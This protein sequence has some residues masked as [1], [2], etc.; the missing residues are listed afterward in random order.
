MRSPDL[1]AIPGLSDKFSREFSLELFR[2]GSYTRQFEY[3]VKNAFDHKL[4]QIPI[5][6][7]IG[8]EF[9]A[10]AYAMML[11]DFQIFAQHR[12]HGIYLSFGASPERLRDELL[13]LPTGCS[14]GMSGSNAIQGPEINM[15]GHSGLMGEQ[16]PIS[17]GAAMASGRPTLTV[18]GD[19]SVE[20]DYIYPSLGYAVSKKLPML[21]IC[22]D[23]GLSILTKVEVRRN[24]SAVDMAG[25]LGMPAVEIS[26]DPW[27][28]AHHIEE[29]KNNLP[30]FINIQTVRNLW[31]SGTGTDGPPEW[32]RY[33]L[34]KSEMVRLGLQAEIEKIEKETT[35]QAEKI[36]EKQLQKLSKK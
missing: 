32:D 25:S 10:A 31:H 26:D 11:K 28:V 17:A 4:L 16:V 6:L 30:G 27:L 21:F 35:L 23:N 34:V 12:A 9:N 5:Y 3:Q 22:E 19:A 8:Q 7:C 15:F 24:W 29:M 33:Q 2:R 18:C 1:G 13:G 14:G 36:W 20:E